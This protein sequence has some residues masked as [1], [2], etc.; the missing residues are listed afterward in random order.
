V[1]SEEKNFFFF[2]FFCH[3]D[4]LG[5]RKIKLFDSGALD[6]VK[7]GDDGIAV[8]RS[9]GADDLDLE[10]WSRFRDTIVGLRE[11]ERC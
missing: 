3:L 9:V 4:V 5:C 1:F 11:C 10:H 6:G 8:V 7:V 2:L